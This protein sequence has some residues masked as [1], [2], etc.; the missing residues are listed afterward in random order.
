M[1][2]PCISSK[3]SRDGA[4]IH[5]GTRLGSPSQ[6]GS[7]PLGHTATKREHSELP[8]H[9]DDAYVDHFCLHFDEDGVVK[10]Q[11]SF[12]VDDKTTDF[13]RPSG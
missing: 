3:C 9:G 2:S 13:Q 6:G 12:V 4:S 1:T 7:C 10:F 11:S 5:D 8:L